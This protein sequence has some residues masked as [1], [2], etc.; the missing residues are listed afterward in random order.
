[1]FGENPNTI[2]HG[3]VSQRRYCVGYYRCWSKKRR[4]ENAGGIIKPEISGNSEVLV[5]VEEHSFGGAGEGIYRFE[6]ATSVADS[7][8]NQFMP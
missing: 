4:V 8:R 3:F 5:V 2:W 7:D 6:Q 1:M